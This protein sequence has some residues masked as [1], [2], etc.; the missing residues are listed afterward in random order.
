MFQIYAITIIEKLQPSK[1]YSQTNSNNCENERNSV[2]LDHRASLQI[3]NV[4][5]NSICDNY[6][7]RQVYQPERS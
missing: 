1:L 3:Q 5:A 4:H 2:R 6:G 7:H